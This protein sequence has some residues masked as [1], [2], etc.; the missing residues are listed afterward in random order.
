MSRTTFRLPPAAAGWPG[1]DNLRQ[2]LVARAEG[3]LR[4]V[5]QKQHLVA[6]RQRRR[7]V[8]DQDDDRSRCLGALD[9]LRAAPLRLAVEIGVGSSSTTRNG[10]P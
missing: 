5:D 7:P 1:A 3:L 6:D 9:R 10:S 2:H 4:A 8:R